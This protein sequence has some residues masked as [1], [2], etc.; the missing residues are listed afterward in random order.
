M[1][2]KSKFH[3]K[4]TKNPKVRVG[5]VTFWHERIP[6]GLTIVDFFRKRSYDRT[7]SEFNTNWSLQYNFGLQTFVSFVSLW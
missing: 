3:H 2:K 5:D 4:D 6:R 1:I 7:K